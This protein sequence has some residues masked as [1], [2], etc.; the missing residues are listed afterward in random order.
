MRFVGIINNDNEFVVADNTRRYE[1]ARLANL[2]ELGDFF[3]EDWA[4]MRECMSFH[5]RNGDF[6]RWYRCIGEN[7]FAD[8]MAR[9]SKEPVWLYT[10]AAYIWLQDR[11]AKKTEAPAVV[12]YD[13]VRDF[14]RQGAIYSDRF[15]SIAKKYGKKS[16]GCALLYGPPGCGK[17]Y[18]AC[19]I[20]KESGKLFAKTCLRELMDNHGAGLERFFEVLEKIGGVVALMDEFEVLGVNRDAEGLNSRMLAN[21][22]LTQMDNFKP[23]TG[24]FVMCSTNSPWLLD[25]AIIR[26]GRLDNLV[27]VGVPDTKTREGLLRH[28]SSD[29]PLDSIDFGKIAEMTEFYSCS[30]MQALCIAAASGPFSRALK[31]GKTHEIRQEDFEMVAK[32]RQCSTALEWFEAA[33]ATPFPESFKSR[34]EP[35]IQEIERYRQWKG[36]KANGSQFR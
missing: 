18:I 31:S 35:M 32:K 28:Y 3:K 6:D 1:F 5:K 19:S 21:M 27:Y 9:F 17:T 30:D 22:L 36:S 2:S 24:A 11:K 8:Y 33:A 34:F 10:G 26:S 13:G 29:M 20:A 23:E 15:R 4:P 12:G 7:E 16:G 14:L 25:S